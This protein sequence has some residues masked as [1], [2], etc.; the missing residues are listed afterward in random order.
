MRE[1]CCIQQRP[2]INRELRMGLFPKQIPLGAQRLML[3]SMFDGIGIIREHSLQ[4][5]RELKREELNLSVPRMQRL[6]PEVHH[7]HPPG[8]SPTLLRGRRAFPA[9]WMELDELSTQH[10]EHRAG[11]NVLNAIFLSP[12]HEP[13]VKCSQQQLQPQHGLAGAQTQ[14]REGAAEWE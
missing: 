6:H 9:P 5:H 11:F 7:P 2:G 3:P 8:I 10:S 14:F 4:Q 13:V 1:N 12:F